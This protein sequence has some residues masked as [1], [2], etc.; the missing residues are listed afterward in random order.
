MVREACWRHD[1]AYLVS[2]RRVTHLEWSLRW[3]NKSRLRA[4]CATNPFRYRSELCIHWPCRQNCARNHETPTPVTA[5][6][7]WRWGNASRPRA[8]CATN[9]FRYRSELCIYWPCREN[10]A[11]N[12]ETPTPVTDSVARPTPGA[13]RSNG[14]AVRRA[15]HAPPRSSPPLRRSAVGGRRPADGGRR[16]AGETRCVALWT[17][18][19]SSGAGP[20][21]VGHRAACCHFQFKLRT[22]PKIAP[23]A[24]LG[25][26]LPAG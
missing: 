4:I 13:R 8:M 14:S 17:D 18:S 20:L 24:K 12:H 1:V 19:V 5:Q 6:G 22:F 26:C 23:L 11:R 16:P 3:G 7:S 21:V 25:R 15:A 2:W 10:C 9:P